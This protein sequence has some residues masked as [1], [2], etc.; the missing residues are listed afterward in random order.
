MRSGGRGQ[1]CSSR[2]DRSS[3]LQASEDAAACWLCSWSLFATEAG[4]A[5]EARAAAAAAWLPAAAGDPV[6]HLRAGHGDALRPARLQQSAAAAP[7]TAGALPMQH[8]LRV[9]RPLGWV[10]HSDCGLQEKSLEQENAELKRQLRQLQAQA[11]QAAQRAPRPPLWV[12]SASCV[13]ASPFGCSTTICLA[14]RSPRSQGGR[15]SG[16]QAMT[17][18]RSAQQRPWCA[19][20]H[21]SPE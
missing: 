18:E 5:T 9:W 11:A 3:A 21:L 6:S 2:P 17:G 14:G 16:E 12:S 10:S 8:T 13:F 19:P 4:P 1:L 15:S 20:R 7:T